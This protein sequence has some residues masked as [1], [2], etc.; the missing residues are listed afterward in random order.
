MDYQKNLLVTAADQKYINIAKQF[1]MDAYFNSGWQGDYMLLAH[2]II[3]SDQCWFKN[4]GILI[5]NCK[6]LISNMPQR[7]PPVVLDKFYLFTPEFKKWK[8]IVYLD[9][10][11]MVQGGLEKLTEIKGFA[12]LNIDFFF[13]KTR[14]EEYFDKSSKH[15]DQRLFN[16]IKTKYDLNSLG[17]SG[18]IL[19]FNTD[20]IQDHLFS[21]I[22]ELVPILNF[23]NWGEE[24]VLN[25]IFNNNWQR[26][27]FLYNIDPL[28][29]RNYCGIGLKKQRAIIFHFDKERKSLM[30][31]HPLCYE[32]ERNATGDNQINLTN[33]P[34]AKIIWTNFMIKRY[35]LYL[36]F[37]YVINTPHYQI[38]KLLGI[39]GIYLSK[40]H[41]KLYL[42]LKKLK[43]KTYLK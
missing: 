32:Q 19:A 7:W 43:I 41:H 23:S 13:K 30:S 11:M 36:Y 34:P 40:N 33:R 27:S 37:M 31:H 6:P 1:F 42:N 22:I 38:N 39:I 5:K 8:N 18:G 20:I 3:E 29:I 14:L 2:N 28:N 4:K 25:L 17:F 35:Q 24:V 9:S 15:F 26:I 12:A 10:D 16:T 21:Q